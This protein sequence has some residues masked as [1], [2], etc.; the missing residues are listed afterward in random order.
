MC[1][2]FGTIA[3]PNGPKRATLGLV[4][5][6]LS[7]TAHRGPDD[8]GIYAEGS[9]GGWSDRDPHNAFPPSP[10]L[11]L[12]HRRLSILDLTIAGHQPMASADGRFHI[13]FNGEI[14]NFRDLRS[15]LVAA[16]HSFVSDSDT[17]VLLQGF[18]EWGENVLDRV[19]GMFAFAIWDRKERA[20]FIARDRLGIKPFYYHLTNGVLSFA[21]EV[22]ALLALP[23]IERAVDWEGMEGQISLLWTPEPKTPFKNIVKLP[24]GFSATFKNGKLKQKQYWEVPSQSQ[25]S[26]SENEL[27]A[28]LLKS[29]DHRMVSDVPVGA[30]LSGG[31]DSSLIVAMMS[32]SKSEPI[33]T[34]TIA[35]REEDRREEAMSSDSGYAQQVASY[36]GTDHHEILIE[37]DMTD[38]LPRMVWHNEEA[39]V[40]PAAINTY[41]ICK[42]AR[43]SDGIKVMLSGM[44]ADEIFAGYRKHLSVQMAEHYKRLPGLLR[45]GLI[46]PMARRLPS[47]GS[48]G[49]YRTFRWAKRFFK[50]ASLPTKDCFIGN[51]SFYSADEM[52]ALMTDDY[53]VTWESSYTVLRHDELLD[54]WPS[55]DPVSAMTSLDTKLFLPSLN[56][57]YSDKA[58]MAASVEVRVPFVDHE[59]VTFALN[60]PSRD[61]L[62]GLKQKHILRQVARG[63]LPAEIVQRP[64]AP[65]GAPLRAW[66]RHDLRELL[67]DTLSEETIRRRGYFKHKEIRRMIDWNL[68]GREDYAHRLWA[69][70]TF[71]L[72]HRMFIDDCD[73][74][75]AST[76]Y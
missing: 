9:H 1:G 62:R 57:A 55:T 24:A 28:L 12:A 20:L 15:D 60:T 10:H 13:V 44:G 3:W 11:V 68:L 33:K 71:E 41:L 40:D 37:P 56:L 64:K 63:Y 32:K 2:I 5:R 48:R 35:F 45:N 21:S 22:K 29:V 46:E 43:S 49:G 58:S 42:Q 69:L 19:N 52:D 4:E 66:M 38:L 7:S 53:R 39:F 16:G 34:Y 14:Y 25:D 54:S 70:L 73:G 74:H 72:W 76:G 27:E 67:E 59:E 51:S 23:W 17:E 50:S 18:V 61:R 26:R 36:L 6:I 30:F 65:F 31:L 47:A 8:R 75:F